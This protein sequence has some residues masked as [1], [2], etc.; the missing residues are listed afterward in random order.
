MLKTDL[1]DQGNGREVWI[2][3]DD[4]TEAD[5]LLDELR[6]APGLQE[7]ADRWETAIA[8]G[9]LRYKLEP[10]EVGRFADF[11]RVEYATHPANSELTR[12]SEFGASGPAAAA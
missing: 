3:V 10:N 6:S 4:R 9:D 2:I 5:S 7:V 1:I 11:V 8:N 12:L